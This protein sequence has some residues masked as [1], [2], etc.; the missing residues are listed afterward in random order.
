VLGRVIEKISGQSY[1]DFIREHILEPVGVEN[2]QMGEGDLEGRKPDEVRYYAPP[3][4]NAYETLGT[5]NR[6]DSAGGWIAS[7]ID[8]MRILVHIDGFDTVPDILEPDTIELLSTPS[9]LSNYAGGFR[10]NSNSGNWWHSGSL[11]GNQ[12][13]I[14]RGSAGFNWVILTNTGSADSEF[15]NRV[16]D[17]I[18]PAVNNPGTEWSEGDLF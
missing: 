3:G 11:N 5:I 9:A 10:I 6:L 4:R 13:W 16:N 18:W 1:E 17:L 15:N 8:L 14:V 12:A 7:P 2:M